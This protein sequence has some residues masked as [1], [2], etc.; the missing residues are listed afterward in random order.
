MNRD[1][2][3]W[4]GVVFS[5]DGTRIVATVQADSEEQASAFARAEWS[6]L[7]G[8]TGETDGFYDVFRRVRTS[9]NPQ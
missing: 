1:S 4:L 9:P 3:P 6:R 7:V 2:K 8:L 5:D